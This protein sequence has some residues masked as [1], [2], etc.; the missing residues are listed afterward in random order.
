MVRH[1]KIQKEVLFL[2]KEFIKLGKQ[3]PGIKS[4]VREEFRKNASIPRT[5]ILRVE[6]LIRLGRKQLDTLKMDDVQS[7]GVFVEDGDKKK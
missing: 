7:M 3:K 2:Y 5:E 4:Y 1:S 6:Y